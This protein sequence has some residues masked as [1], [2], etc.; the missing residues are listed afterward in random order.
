MASTPG[1][2]GD[3]MPVR[4]S[5]H[6]P[7]LDGIRALAVWMVLGDHMVDGWTLPEAARAAIP[8]WMMFIL[9]HGWL[10]VDLFFILSG[11]LIT[12][13]LLDSREK[14]GYFRNF[15]AR[16]F[17]RIIPLYF[18]VIG[19][20][21]LGYP[22]GSRYFVLSLL[23]LANF[24]SAFGA[25]VPHGPAVFW[26]L[27][28]EEHFY[29]VWPWTVR[30]L[31][32][33][34]LAFTAGAITVIMP[35][36]RVW[37]LRAGWFTVSQIYSYSFF[38]FDGLAM[39]ALLAIWVRSGRAN[40]RTSLQLAAGLIVLAI[41]I[42]V[43]GLPFG[44]MSRGSVLRYTQAALVFAGVVL[45]AIALRG[46][47]YCAPL[48]WWFAKLSGDLSYCIYLIHLG[49]G[50]AYQYLMGVCGVDQVAVFGPL[51]SVF[52]R[53]FFA[54]SLSFAIA[55]ASRRFLEKPVLQLKRYF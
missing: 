34:A 11:F 38:R 45:A 17:L 6:I 19:V 33:R 20:M 51:G 44:I 18:T 1:T 46:S 36:L 41:A 48:R 4:A 16:R 10:G 24:A 2:T 13:I 28:I 22:S 8:N 53:S 37:V 52:A 54:I 9:G 5:M 35:I 29:L 40:R 25:R 43:A 50:D 3:K 30:F 14:P 27:A 15:Y 55:L 23:F 32:P 42:T 21:W 31:K 49:V 26:S 7:E 12:G 47:V 39:G